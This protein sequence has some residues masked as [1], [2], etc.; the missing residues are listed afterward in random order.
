MK[1]TTKM[2][3]TLLLTLAVA[4]TAFG[5]TTA[6]AP[7]KGD[8]TTPTTTVTE[9]P[10]RTPLSI[11][12]IQGP[13]GVGL[14]NLM[15]SAPH[16]KAI[17]YSFTIASS[18]DEVVGKFSNGD[19]QIAS[20]PT[21]LAAK[22]SKKLGG[23]VQ[24][25]ALNTAGVLYMLENG[26][27][28]HSVADLRGKTIYST[29]E[30]ANPEYV[31]RHIL[32]KNGIDPD[33]DVTIEFLAENSELVAKLATGEIS[34][35]MVPEP[36]AT[37]AMTKNP[38]LRMAISMDAAWKAVEPDSTMMMGCVIAKKSFVKANTDAVKAFL[39]EYK[40][41]V[42]AV[43][44]VDATAEL[45]ADFGIIAAAPIAKKA[46]PRCNVV[47][48]EGA[49]MKPAIHGYYEILFEADPTSIGG[50]VPNDDFYFVP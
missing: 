4:F 20:V 45:C 10:K 37:T 49:A 7:E 8:D 25:L 23:D 26:N 24:V 44:D 16:S 27:K 2:L 19:V 33:K 39:A 48:V 43:A 12:G 31:L 14:A 17:E 35:A 21:N 36:A 29:G 28:V 9:A 38:D 32:K 30:G 3:L 1:H 13:T 41:S 50:A 47:F 5:C 6:P 18:P 40:T 42:E 46:I 22:L 15:K 11:A 34:L